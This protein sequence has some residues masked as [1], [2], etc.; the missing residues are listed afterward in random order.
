MNKCKRLGRKITRME[1]FLLKVMITLFLAFTIATLTFVFFDN[2]RIMEHFKLYTMVF[3]ALTA[4][5]Y[6]K[7]TIEINRLIHQK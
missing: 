6:T 4:C 1:L 2:A 3:V 5:L 7:F